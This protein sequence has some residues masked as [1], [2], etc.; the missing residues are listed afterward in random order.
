MHFPFSLRKPAFYGHFAAWLLLS[1]VPLDAGLTNRWSFSNASGTAPAGT[2]I[3]DS[4]S[5]QSATVRGVGA[6]FSSGSIT[7]PGSS[8]G[9]NPP[10]TISG[11]V[12]LPNG[13]ISS[14]TSLT[15][16]FWATPVSFK[17]YQRLWDL[18]RTVQAGDGLGAPG[19]ITGLATTAPGTT[20]ASDSLTLSM[21]KAT[22]LNEQRFEAKLNGTT[23]TADPAGLFRQ[24]DTTLATTAGTQYH[25]VLT[26]S[27]GGGTFGSTGGRVSWYRNGTLCATADVGFR[28]S[29]LEDVNNWLGRSL[30]SADRCANVSYNEVRLYDHAMSSTE[31]SASYTAGANPPSPVAVPDTVSIHRNQ[32]VRVAVLANDTGNTTG[33]SV[34]ITQAPQFGTAVPDNAGRILYSHTSGSPASDSVGYR[35]NGP[36]GTSAPA[37]LTINFAN[38]LR[39]SNSTL[40]V[41]AT[42]PPL[43][44]QLV[45]AF[46]G[47]TSP[48]A[49]ASPPGDTQRLFVCE[50][51]GL[52]RFIPSV[53]ATTPTISTFLDLPTLLSSRG[54]SMSTGGEQGLLGIT[55]HPNYAVNRYFYIFYSVTIG[56][57]TYERVSRFTTQAANPSA[58]DTSSEL[59]L[60][61][62]VDEASNHN[63]GD[64]HF[65][66]DGYL[67]ISFGDEGGQNDQYNNTQNITK[68]FFSAIIRID[69]DKKAGSLTPNTHAAIPLDSGVARFTI[70]NDNPFVGATTF[71]GA[72]VTPASVR[73]EFW[74]VGLRNPWRFSFDSLTGEL[75]AADVGSNTYEEVDIIAKGSNYGWAFREG[76]HNGPKSS[77]AP[78]NFDTLYHKAPLYEYTHSGGDS[79][80]TGSS[81]SGGI[82]YRGTRVSGLSGA[83]IFGDYVTGNI[84]SLVRNGANPPTVTRIAGEVGVVAFG[85][86]PSNGDVLI[87]DLDGNRILRLTSDTVVDNFPATLSATG[88][89]ADLASLSPAPGLLPYEPNL[90][91]WSDYAIKRRWFIIPNLADKMTSSPDNSWT[92]P[93]GQIWVKHFDLE[94][95]RG[96]PATKKRIETR[97]LVKNATGSYGVSYRWNDAG[98]EATL[99]PDGGVDVDL[100]LI[101]NG[102]PYTQRWR[103]PSRSECLACHTPQAGHALSFNT[104]QLNLTYTTNGFTGNQLTLLESAAYLTN[105]L[106][107]PNLLPHHLAPDDPAFPVEARVRS[108]LAVNCAYCHK[109]GG[110][111]APAAW[112]GR[113][114][115]S[116]AQTGLIDGPALNNGGNALNRLVISGDLAHSV[117]YNRVA[118]T[119]GFTRMPPLGTSE[120]DPKAL[121]LLSEWINQSLPAKKTYQQWRLEKFASNSTPQGESTADPDGDGRTN[122]NEYLTATDP[123]NGNSFFSASPA[124]SGNQFRLNF[125]VPANQS[126]QVETSDNLQTWTLWDV[127]G[128]HGIPRTGE[129]VTLQGSASD[130]RSFFRVK[131]QDH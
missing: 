97:L 124:I 6:T 48:V 38:T 59:I 99:A 100:R 74:A 68:D 65:G 70:P 36:G 88:L 82:V 52:V 12:D 92:F 58:A 44:I 5:G 126:A 13:L 119:N 60:I 94:T 69:V 117:V 37:T 29:Q 17:S 49:M 113:P 125:Y 2:S 122:Q 21:S 55:F 112:D 78:A 91:F 93:A 4:V 10:N 96:D 87:A 129:S 56:S 104:R 72:A 75:W 123:L 81:V 15:L 110:T 39:L 26:F 24:V 47:I 31:I 90:S 20:Q 35:I 34:T 86:D 118:N 83:Y 14:K 9:D 116:L 66:P 61:Q 85:A 57:T 25:Y 7:L 95:T 43:S 18:G 23:K 114:E 33:A 11:Y 1:V 79:N 89:F 22:N 50:K 30:W 80:F 71:L 51:G 84:W 107:S 54:H 8:T 42:A 16:E 27:D 53:T 98:T 101:V 41:P 115:L 108:Y 46:T 103:I 128:N 102:G 3:T 73:T 109:A 106:G 120:L 121:A 76:N 63:G 67:Y 130:A 28:L 32:K 64:L 62:Q 45:P 127:S 19:E 111:A 77:S 131:L 105:S 40:N